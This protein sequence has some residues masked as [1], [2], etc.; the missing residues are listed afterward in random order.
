MNEPLLDET[1]A[2]RWRGVALAI[3]VAAVAVIVSTYHV[4]NNMYDE[5]AHIAAGMEWLA[6][7][8]Y[9][10][11][12]QHPPLA[13]VAA[14]IGPY[15]AG[16]RGTGDWRGHMYEEG[17]RILGE[18]AHYAHTLTLARLGELPF[19][20]ILVATAWY[21]A[22]RVAGEREATMATL[23]VCTNP[24]VLGHA[25][26]AGTDMG[27]AALMPAALL[28]WTIWLERASAKRTLA[29]GVLVALCGLT[30]FNGLAYLLPAAIGVAVFASMGRSRDVWNRSRVRMLGV[31]VAT[32]IVVTWV[33][34][35]F[36]VGRYHG[37]LLPAPELFAG[38]AAFFHHGTGG[39]PSYLFGRVRSG[40]WWYYD[41][42]A[43]LVKTPIPLLL[44]SGLGGFL[45]TKELRVVR[46]GRDSVRPDARMIERA[47][48]LMGIAS[49]LGVASATPVDIG[50]RLD[51][52]IYPMMAVLGGVAFVW[53]WDRATRASNRFAVG[54]LIAWSV[55]EVALAHP[56]HVAY[57]NQL[58]GPEP[59]RILVDSNLDWGQDLYRLRDV[60]NELGVDS[61][62]VHY[63]GTAE[64]TAVGLTRTR[65]LHP[66]ERTTG[67]IA[68]SE[69]FYAGVW[70]DT[71]LNWLHAYRPVA[72]V[73]KSIRLY[74][75]TR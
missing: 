50:I 7:G 73:G 33:T 9:T 17:R 70:S 4:F 52:A 34:Y 13:R 36:S 71:S 74:F 21:W 45:V 75:I 53:A 11:E 57:F 56:D 12:P 30:K 49:V 25:G 54:A 38:L 63:F 43:V 59:E 1:I 64:F 61:L 27:P 46:R 14:A 2:R 58:A 62:R 41:L 29:L 35:R 40:G 42:V 3:A 23:L 32:A 26:V 39:H 18:G 48:L 65:R 28:A 20:L 44:L 16:E 19:F 5:P 31:A 8:S 66:N 68:A 55:L 72:R 51:L 22:R 67:W 37:V 69:T 24:S 15:L 6:H 60:A 47:A 10:Y